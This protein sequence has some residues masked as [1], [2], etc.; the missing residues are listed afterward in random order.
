MGL[1]GA[2]CLALVSSCPNLSSYARW[3][4]K[5]GKGSVCCAAAL[6]VLVA[7]T[8]CPAEEV[9]AGKD[10]LWSIVSMLVGLIRAN[11]D[12]RPHEGGSE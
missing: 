9:S 6:E 4:K 12:C 11:S 10:R 7:K 2:S 3:K 8:P 5:P 1:T